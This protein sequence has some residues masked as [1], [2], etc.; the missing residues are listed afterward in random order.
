MAKRR[1]KSQT[2]YAKNFL[3]YSSYRKKAYD[4]YVK[5][6]RKVA[7]TYGN[8]M[9]DMYDYQTF[10]ETQKDYI[11]LGPT[12]Y[13]KKTGKKVTYLGK[14]KS[15]RWIVYRQIDSTLSESEAGVKNLKNS[16]RKL[17]DKVNKGQLDIDDKKQQDDPEVMFIKKL[18]DL[19]H[20]K[21]EITEDKKIVLVDDV[22]I[23]V[24]DFRAQTPAWQKIYDFLKDNNMSSGVIGT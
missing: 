22:N 17:V 7:E 6:Y 21:L 4:K 18:I 5:Q 11:A 19:G 23:S 20:I 9:R 2:T 3:K 16:V 15:A 24:K 8:A 13:Q 1:K 12:Y 10:V 14:V